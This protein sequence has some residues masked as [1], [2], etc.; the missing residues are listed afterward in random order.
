MSCQIG[1]Y[2]LNFTD[3]EIKCLRGDALAEGS[4]AGRWQSWDS[5]PVPLPQIR[6]LAMQKL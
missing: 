5:T 4:P 6:V 1:K 2:H 3:E